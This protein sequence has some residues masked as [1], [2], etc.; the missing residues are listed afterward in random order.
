MAENERRDRSFPGHVLDGSFGSEMD[1]EE[2]CKLKFAQSSSKQG[3][4]SEEE[5]PLIDLEDDAVFVNSTESQ[6]NK[7]TKKE[8][9]QARITTMRPPGLPLIGNLYQLNQQFLHKYLW[10]LSKKYGPLMSMN[11]GFSQLVVISSARIAKEAMK[12]QDFAFSSRPSF[13]GCR[14]LALR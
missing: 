4:S 5:K 13:L 14:L 2:P 8:K 1:G 11:L 7:N 9:R 12:T 6:N 10:Q 3:S